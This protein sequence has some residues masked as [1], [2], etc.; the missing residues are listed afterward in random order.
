MVMLYL[1]N[2]SVLEDSEH[3]VEVNLSHQ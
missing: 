1:Y 2:I 3:H